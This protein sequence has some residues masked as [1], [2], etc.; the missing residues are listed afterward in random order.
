MGTRLAWLGDGASRMEV[1]H[2][3]QV[4]PEF[5]ASGTQLGVTYELRY[6]LEQ[7][8][9]RLELVGERTL[10]LE[11]DEADFFDLGWSPLFNSLPVIRDRL[12]EPGPP[13]DYLMRWVD[14][15]SRACV[16]QRRD[17]LRDTHHVMTEESATPAPVELVRSLFVAAQR[18]DLDAI[19]GLLR[20]DAVF[21][22]LALRLRLEGAAAIRGFLEELIGTYDE[23]DVEINEVGELAPGIVFAASRSEARLP[24]SAAVIRQRTAWVFVFVHALIGRATG[25]LDVDEGRA[26][27]ERLAE[28][29]W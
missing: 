3:E 8:A 2:V 27:A 25:Y 7:G 26:A 1:A 28:E 15:P 13:R 23:Y 5:V 29:R 9:L 21:E 18:K 11:L 16:P 14:V 20:H 4:A 22:S 6:R 10:E 12:L 17:G 24:G 19:T